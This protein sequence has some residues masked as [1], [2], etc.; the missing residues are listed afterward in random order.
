[1]GSCKEWL[2]GCGNAEVAWYNLMRGQDGCVRRVCCV[3]SCNEL[4]SG[5]GDDEVAWDIMRGLD[6]CANVLVAWEE[7]VAWEL[8]GVLREPRSR[9][10]RWTDYWASMWYSNRRVIQS[11]ASAAPLARLASNKLLFLSMLNPHASSYP[12]INDEHTSSLP[13]L[14][15][16][17]VWMFCVCFV[18][19]GLPLTYIL[20]LVN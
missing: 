8:C 19:V 2:S 10:L 15:M 20:E 4:L 17:I 11:W 16:Q 18:V 6:G 9:Q 3:S 14:L 12:E 7:M 13:F 5:C 1:M